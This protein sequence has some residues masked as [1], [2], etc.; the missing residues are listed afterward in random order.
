MQ[1]VDYRKK[2]AENQDFRKSQEELHLSFAFGDAVIRE[3]LR[4]GWSQA[5][6]A[7][8]AGTKQANISRIEAG[9]ANPTLH[10]I[11][12]LCI[13]LNLGIQFKSGEFGSV[14]PEEL[15]IEV[16]QSF[17]EPGYEIPERSVYLVREDGEDKKS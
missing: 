1:Y 9:L 5:E 14:R 12:K 7:R 13:A 15:D 4:K 16:H 6:L 11:Q 2:L 10:L 17:V 8:K 3:R